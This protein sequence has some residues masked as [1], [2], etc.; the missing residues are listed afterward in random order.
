VLSP[1][2]ILSPPSS[3]CPFIPAKTKKKRVFKCYY[4]NLVYFYN[5]CLT[6]ETAYL[7]IVSVV[8]CPYI[9]LPH[10]YRV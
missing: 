3:H 8:K 10:I 9:S 4:W 7:W 1:S 2:S 5:N 6:S